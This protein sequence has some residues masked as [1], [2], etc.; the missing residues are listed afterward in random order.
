MIDYS[1]LS[2]EN[3]RKYGTDIGRIGQMLLANRY[4][5][6]SHF[7]YELLQNA[8]DALKRRPQDWERRTVRFELIETQLAISHFGE[9]FSE[10]DVRGVCGID[11]ST[12]DIT[13]IGRFGIGFKSV[14]A[15]T[16]RPEVHSD[17]VH[18]AIERYVHPIEAV[19]I[20]CKQEET[21]I[22]LPFRKDDSDAFREIAEALRQLGP[23]TLLFLRQIDGIEWSA[24]GKGE[25]TYVRNPRR[26]L[27]F[28][29]ERITIAGEDKDPATSS[30]YSEDWIV[31]PQ[32]VK[33]ETGI[34]VGHAE[35][36]FL[37][38]Y[39]SGTDSPTRV[40]PATNT[41]LVVYFPTI[42]ATDVGFLIQGPYRTTPSRDNI[43]SDDSW[44]RS[45]VDTTAELLVSALEG[46]RELG[47]LDPG[48]LQT[49]PV[50]QETFGDKHMFRPLFEATLTAFRQHRLLPTHYGDYIVAGC[51]KLARGRG[52]QKL[53][54]PQQLSVLFAD[55]EAA[56][57]LA[58]GITPDLTPRLQ[59]F[60]V[61]ELDVEEIR[62]EDIVRQL[63]AR[64]LK[65]QKDSW[66]E[67]LYAFLAGQPALRSRGLLDHV[68]LVRL[69]DGSHVSVRDEDG[70]P[71]AFL[72]GKTET[73][74]PI[75]RDEVCSKAEAHEFLRLLGL[76]EPDLVDDVIAHVL[77]RY[78]S[79]N[80]SLGEQYASDLGRI[81]TAIKT[82]SSE[83]RERLKKA[84]SITP[85]VA[86]F[87][88][89]SKEP[90][91]VCPGEVYIATER[92]E[93]LFD[94]VEGVLLV[95][96][97]QALRTEQGRDMLVAVGAARYLTAEACKRN[98]SPNELLDMRTN[99]GCSPNTGPSE[100]HDRT[101]RGLDGLLDLLPTLEI[102]VAKRK[103]ALLWEA[104]ND[105]EQRS[106]NSAFQGTYQWFYVNQRNCSFDAAF[107]ERLRTSDWIVDKNGILCSPAEITFDELGWEDNHALVEKL[108]FK[109]RHLDQ[110]ALDA[111]FEPQVL[112][113]LKMHGLTTESQLQALLK[114]YFDDE[115]PGSSDQDDEHADDHSDTE[116]ASTDEAENGGT[117]G[118]GRS[119]GGT[120]KGT[121]RRKLITYI[122]IGGND[123]PTEEGSEA[124]AENMEL[125]EHGIRLILE[126]EPHLQ[127]TGINNPGFD[128]VEKDATDRELRWVE[129]KAI[130]GPF[131]E[132]SWVALSRKQFDTALNREEDYWLYVVEHAATPDL[133][134]IIRVK[135][136]AGQA[137]TF[138]FDHGW[139]ALATETP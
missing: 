73:D 93:E 6:R 34:E 116:G 45:L 127:R 89:S 57:W 12:K 43:V 40:L 115:P 112:T 26:S 90:V 62:P 76:S 87:D 100:V 21:R 77:P 65:D 4:S 103:G 118:G 124:Y 69:E 114:R 70:N 108:G 51:A 2:E 102:D 31:F 30:D 13:A 47:L 82:D 44:N 84:L 131:S 29:A 15:Y 94:G 32:S 46:L 129:V 24:V 37:V 7:I 36:A 11:E 97:V 83:R 23:R 53:L 52:L 106:G 16:D 117:S 17:M 91:F 139:R 133:A 75:V 50:N 72:P 5:D 68:E 18:F 67:E 25:G 95:A 48:A 33:N 88:A 22:V 42:V 120:T 38:E 79:G 98:F 128:L 130:S 138:V 61:Q 123:S 134:N 60:L 86:A 121:K 19:P 54:D 66:I 1:A 27:S 99:A 58:R 85:F 41:E 56:K 119:N 110:L 8:E 63:D 122:H 92:L 9:P 49:L 55:G 14:N 111:G 64:F 137:R 74:F 39:D 59:N 35:L 3:E 113:L 104:L 109:P 28:G 96:D 71:C 105:L 136:P 107:V 101:L 132:D 81:L 135:N 20:P 80:G 78:S 126:E 125:E 10:D